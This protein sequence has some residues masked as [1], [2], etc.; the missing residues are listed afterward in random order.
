MDQ[1]T[2]TPSVV[3][4]PSGVPN[5][6][7]TGPVAGLIIV[8]ILIGGAGYYLSYYN[9]PTP[10]PSVSVSQTSTSTVSPMPTSWPMTD[11]DGIIW[12]AGTRKINEDLN[13]LDK[14]PEATYYLL[15]ND[16]GKDIVVAEV[17]GLGSSWYFFLKKNGTYTLLTR[18]S[19]EGLSNIPQDTVTRYASLEFPDTVNFRGVKLTKAVYF[20]GSFVLADQF[21]Q[22]IKIADTEYG[23]LSV[24]Q[25]DNNG[26]TQIAYDLTLPSGLHGPY[27]YHPAFLTDDQ[28][29][30]ITWSDGTV[31]KEG[32][33][34]T[35]Y[36]ETVE[37]LTTPNIQDL[38]V[39][40]TTSTNEPVYQFK[41][42]RD[43]LVLSILTNM[44]NPTGGKITPEEY[45]AQHG[46]IIYHDPLDRWVLLKSKHFVPP[47]ERA[48]PVI[49]LYPEQKETVSVR[50]F[51]SRSFTKTDPE[52]GNGWLVEADPSGRITNLRDGMQYPY[53][54]WESAED[55]SIATPKKGFV[56]ARHEVASLLHDKLSQ[57][58]LNKKEQDDFVEFWEPR[59]SRTPYYFITFISSSEIERTAPMSIEPTPDTVIRVLMDYRPLMEP[60]SVEPLSIPATERRGF[61][62][63]EWGGIVRDTWTR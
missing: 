3:P 16:H 9:N 2:P 18:Y 44:Y 4:V 57:F 23:T 10:T 56:V 33:S 59:L 20:L 15:G 1:T 62:V 61:T 41:N 27:N 17:P 36:T 29:P 39:A 12:Y 53:L 24:D 48:K 11:K 49:Y 32:Y 13:L 21:D 26:I 35:F 25:K 63:V 46:L 37:I 6:F 28:I 47:A 50:V 54:F 51:P 22:S 58:G 5:K 14:T 30:N 42:P 40:G 34:D 38:K 8:L 60:I 19:D 55:G 43:P 45:A 52:Y 31:N 7:P